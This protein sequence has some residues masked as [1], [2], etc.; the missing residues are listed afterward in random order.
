M[1][2]ITRLPNGLRVVT[3]QMK[4]TGAVS[5]YFYTGVGSKH[6]S[7]S[8]MGIS[9]FLEHMAFKG[10]KTRNA[11]EIAEQFDD[12]G[13]LINA[14]T[15]REN[16]V[17]Y[18]KVLQNDFAKGFEIMADIILNSVFNE[19]EIESERG[20]ILQ[21]IAMSR[22]VPEEM[23]FDSFYEVAYPGQSIGH[24]ILGTEK[25]VNTISRDNIVNFVNDN[26]FPENIVVSVAGNINHEHVV[27]IV[28]KYMPMQKTGKK[29]PVI[30]SS[31]KG[32]DFRLAK[33]TEQTQILLGLGGVSL[34]DEDMYTSQ[35]LS[36]IAG[37]GMSSRLFQEV[38]E[39]R[40]LAYTVS[41]SSSSYEDSGVFKIYAAT[42]H[43]KVNEFIN[44]TC[45]EMRG[46]LNGIGEKELNRAKAQAK[47]G[48]IMAMESSGFFASEIGMQIMSY[49]KIIEM[50]TIIEKIENIS[51]KDV[52]NLL[53]KILK[54]KPTV[55]ILGEVKNILEY[56]EVK[57]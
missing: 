12:I 37:G 53:D 24:N 13:G 17:Y 9:H 20:V 38:R 54:T 16:T 8:Q 34:F 44:V 26:Y 46:I 3:R 39:K 50:E 52:L 40:G 33:D 32:G 35:V 55:C 36:L 29:S 11:Q 41:T 18:A 10:T 5:M 4:D 15:S 56:D 6:E 23:I 48:I 7:E 30:K 57:F 42:A 45:K 31:Y 25:T 51:S 49:D 14:Y 43:D 47:S 22:D 2:K 28:N 27:D 21:E 1:N 19:N